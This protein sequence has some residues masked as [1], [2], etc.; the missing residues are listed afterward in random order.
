MSFEIIKIDDIANVMTGLVV[1]RKEAEILENTVKSYKMLTLKSFDQG[2]WLNTDE[3]DTFDSTEELDDKYLTQLGDV[4]IRL[5]FPHTA[6]SI[7]LNNEGLLIPSLFSVI[8]S[9][10]NT[11]LPEFL[12]IYLN[13]DVMK[14]FYEKT[15]IGSTIQIIK[16]SMLKELI[17]SCPCLERQKKIVEVNLLIFKERRL[18]DNLVNQK[19]TYHREV[20]TQLLTR[21]NNNEYKKA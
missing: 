9:K 12:S 16:T 5:S 3:L 10:K 2:G 18:L 13:S 20:L 19:I 7:D 21:E 8:R 1:K 4:I 6:I 14:K 15:S 17:L 11:I